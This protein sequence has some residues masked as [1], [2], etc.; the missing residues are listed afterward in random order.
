M[1]V[2]MDFGAFLANRGYFQ[3]FHVSLE[4][5]SCT[6][7]PE[8]SANASEDANLNAL[9]TCMWLFG[10]KNWDYQ[11]VGSVDVPQVLRGEKDRVD[12]KSLAQIFVEIAQELGN[13]LRAMPDAKVPR[14]RD[15]GGQAVQI[16]KPG[17]RL[18]TSRD[19]MCIGGTTGDQEIEGRWCFGDH[20]VAKF[21]D[22]HAWDPTFNIPNKVHRYD[23]GN[24][25]GGGAHDGWWAKEETD[26][27]YQN[28]TKW[29]APG[30]PTV[31][32]FNEGAGRGLVYTYS[33]WDG[34][35]PLLDLASQWIDQFKTTDTSAF[36]ELK[37]L[38]KR[39]GP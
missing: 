31:Y 17:Y 29:V 1:A 7:S 18:V 23:G 8:I 13:A 37:N 12:C 32:C 16:A 10:R 15:Y 30:R 2:M 11:P 39:S 4:I 27:T 6:G 24:Y 9:L 35:K 21:A 33:S 19:L 26:K 14:R 34:K 38:Q 5:V 20:W 25:T 22:G 3:R 36:G 28:N